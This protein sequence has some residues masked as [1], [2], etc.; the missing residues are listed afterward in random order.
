MID[1]NLWNSSEWLQSKTNYTGTLQRAPF[2]LFTI[3]LLPLSPPPPQVNVGPKRGHVIRRSSW[4]RWAR[5]TVTAGEV[6]EGNFCREIIICVA[7]LTKKGWSVLD[8]LSR[9]VIPN[10]PNS[11]S[12][13]K[14]EYCYWSS[15]WRWGSILGFFSDTM[16]CSLLGTSSIPN[17]IKNNTNIQLYNCLSWSNSPVK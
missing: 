8:N 10:L 11:L 16:R 17:F 6:W 13:R 12:N 7:N 2:S 15:T 5:S 14:D 3:W 9:I 1:S 4:A